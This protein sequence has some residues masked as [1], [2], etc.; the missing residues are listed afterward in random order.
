MALWSPRLTG[1]APCDGADFEDGAPS[2]KTFNLLI[3]L[4]VSKS[5]S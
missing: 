4:L 1:K 2:K 5:S 3:V